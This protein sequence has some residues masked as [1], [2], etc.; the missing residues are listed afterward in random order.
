MDQT[1]LAAHEVHERAK[2]DEIDNLAIIDFADLGLFDNALD[3]CN[4]RIDLGF[5][6][7]GNLDQAFVVDI[8]LRAGFGNDFADHLAAGPDN[9]A[10]LFLVD[11][12]RF[13]TRSMFGHFGTNR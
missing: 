8:D 11:L 5:V 7:R 4:R 3:P 1:V 13:D 2:V 12:Q 6:G 10:D 9:V